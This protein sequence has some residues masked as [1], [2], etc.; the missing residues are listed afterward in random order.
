MAHTA[1]PRGST[2]QAAIVIISV[3][4]LVA[5]GMIRRSTTELE[6]AGARRGYDVALSCA[7]GAR[8]L[9]VSQFRTYGVVLTSLQLDETVADRRYAS[10]HY[11][12]FGVR[13]VTPVDPGL[14][15]GTSD[16]AMDVANRSARIQVGGAAYRISVV[17]SDS[18]ESNRQSEIEFVVRFGM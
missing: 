13:T 2:L 14:I 7:D 12:H 15:G 5:A 11:D 1:S 18:R 8:E 17:C 6:A 9:L 3:L 16:N 10:G 4:T